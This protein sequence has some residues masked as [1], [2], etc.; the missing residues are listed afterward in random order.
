VPTGIE[1]AEEW[2]VM[3]GSQ[4]KCYHK[5]TWRKSRYGKSH[6][7]TVCGRDSSVYW[8]YQ[9]QRHNAHGQYRP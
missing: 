1:R 2:V 8:M 5:P 4:S 3:C 9:V 6:L 7:R